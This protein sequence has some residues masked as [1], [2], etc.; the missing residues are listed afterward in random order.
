MRVESPEELD[1]LSED[2]LWAVAAN[3]ANDPALRHEAIR[4]WLYP[5]IDGTTPDEE[6][7]R[8]DELCA[9]AT[10]IERDE[11]EEDDIE[12]LHRQGPYF[13]GAG[14]L[15]VE[16]NGAMYLIDHDE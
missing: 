8:M 4:T 2:E 6:P 16:Y 13:D 10:R 11:V 7:A 14:R 15:I 5:E 1:T 3:T 9:R 12:E